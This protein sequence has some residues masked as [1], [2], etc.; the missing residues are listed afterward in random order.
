MPNQNNIIVGPASLSI[1][2]V[3]VGYT[4]G[5]VSLRKS[6]EF[7]DVDADQLAGVARKVQTFERMFLTTTMIEMTLLNMRN[8]MNEPSS[9]SHSG[10]QLDFGHSDP[11]AQEYE[12]T[13]VGDAPTPAGMTVRT[14]TFYRA[15]SVDEVET[16]I[17]SR[18][19]ASILP[20]GFELLK[21]PAKNSKFGNFV[22][23]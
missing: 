5:G 7:V 14:Y 4:Q 19:S 20:V 13:V 6:N 17:G 15:I 11:V 12:L 16:L 9:N 21:D 10:S 23:S 2:N 1:D 22:D 18:D 3:D 8:V